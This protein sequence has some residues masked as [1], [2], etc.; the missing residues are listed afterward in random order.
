MTL[1]SRWINRDSETITDKFSSNDLTLVTGTTTFTTWMGGKSLQFDDLTRYSASNECMFDFDFCQAF[2][3]SM[4]IYPDSSTVDTFPSMINKHT[5]A[6]GQPGWVMYWDR[7]NTRLGFKPQHQDCCLNWDSTTTGGSVPAC[8]WTYVT[9][10]YAGMCNRN[11]ITLYINAVSC[12][13]GSCCSAGCDSM[14][15]NEPIRIGDVSAGSAFY[16]GGLSDIRIY[17]HELSAQE[18]SCLIHIEALNGSVLSKSKLPSFAKLSVVALLKQN[19]LQSIRP[20][21]NRDVPQQQIEA[22][23]HPLLSVKLHSNLYC[24]TKQHGLGSA[25]AASGTIP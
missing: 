19:A 20:Q 11:G 23:L 4:W 16:R 21:V 2:S 24:A 5:G 15:N 18:V 3:V 8:K 1:V 9:A 10:T 25:G 6:F 17:N 22:Q 13:V 14:L 7:N 12:T